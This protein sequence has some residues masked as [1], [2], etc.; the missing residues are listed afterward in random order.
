[1]HTCTRLLQESFASDAPLLSVMQNNDDNDHDV[2]SL[3]LS[4]HDLHGPPRW[5]LPSTVPCSTILVS[6]L[7]RQTWQNHDNLQRWMSC[8]IKETS[9]YTLFVFAKVTCAFAFQRHLLDAATQ[10]QINTNCHWSMTH[11]LNCPKSDWKQTKMEK[12]W[13]M[14][15][16]HVH[17]VCWRNGKDYLPHLTAVLWTSRQDEWTAEV[18]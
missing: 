12:E 13:K 17:T 4:F 3:V 6:V 16:I 9:K 5:W 14:K 18:T 11:F 8:F 10:Q 15:P 2:H 1:M 7:W